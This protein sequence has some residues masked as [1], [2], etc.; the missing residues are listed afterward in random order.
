M[1]KLQGMKAIAAH[2]GRSESTMLTWIRDL[3]YPATKI[4]GTWESSTEES[5][6]WHKKQMAL[7]SDFAPNKKKE[8]KEKKIE[9]LV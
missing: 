8:Q 5:E 4:G 1:A 7:A 9:T 2:E 6:K 3:D